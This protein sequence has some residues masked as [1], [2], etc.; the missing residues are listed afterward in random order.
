[1]AVRPPGCRCSGGNDEEQAANTVNAAN[2]SASTMAIIASMPALP[3]GFGLHGTHRSFL[4][5]T[6]Q[7]ILQSVA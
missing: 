1:M 4:G 3:S 7:F 5:S 6:R 2:L